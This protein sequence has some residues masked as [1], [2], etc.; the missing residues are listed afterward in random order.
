M[1]IGHSSDVV[2][3]LAS[4]QCGSPVRIGLV[5]VLDGGAALEAE[6]HRRFAGQRAHGEWFTF[7]GALRAFVVEHHDDWTPP[8]SLFGV[9]WQ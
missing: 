7:D 9:P 2:K 4:H 6:L 1:K 8:H 3:R 5:L